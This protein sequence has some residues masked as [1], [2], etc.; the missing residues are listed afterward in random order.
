MKKGLIVKLDAAFEGIVRCHAETTSEFWLTH[1]LQAVLDYARWE[2]FSKIIDKTKASCKTAGDW[3]DNPSK[4]PISFT[5]VYFALQTR[6]QELIEQC[7]AESEH[8]KARKKLTISEEQ[9]SGVICGRVGEEQSFEHIKHNSDARA[10]LS[11]R[12]IVPEQLPH[13]GDLN[14]S[15]ACIQLRPRSRRRHQSG[16]MMSQHISSQQKVKL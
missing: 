13:A 16:W 14:G 1:E 6:K 9:L 2:K 3:I 10:L 4:D 11:E 7:L 8:L 12:G 5:H 15:S